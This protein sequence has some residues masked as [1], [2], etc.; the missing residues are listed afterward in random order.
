MITYAQRERMFWFG[1]EALILARSSRQCKN[2]A[3]FLLQW[4]RQLLYYYS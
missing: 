4:T 2:F 1:G 3:R